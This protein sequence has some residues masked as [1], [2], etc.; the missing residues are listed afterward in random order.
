M[1]KVMQKTAAK[2][3]FIITIIVA[4]CTLWQEVFISES[5]WLARDD[6]LSMNCFITGD[7]NFGEV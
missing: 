6:I 4:T 5:E 7:S 2:V 1:A 3:F